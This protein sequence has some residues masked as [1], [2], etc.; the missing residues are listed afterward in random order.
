[1]SAFSELRAEELWS[2]DRITPEQPFRAKVVA[3]Q[4]GWGWDTIVLKEIGGDERY[5]LATFGNPIGDYQILRKEELD[6]E[7]MKKNGAIFLD[8]PVEI[9]RFSW[10]IGIWRHGRVF[11]DEDAATKH[12]KKTGEQGVAPQSATRSESDSEGDHK[13]QPESEARSR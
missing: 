13:P 11:G 8:P 4:P 2:E 7:A 3:V 5:C 12:R 10:S 1:M 6:A 9:A